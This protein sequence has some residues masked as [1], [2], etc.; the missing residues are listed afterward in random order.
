MGKG[1]LIASNPKNCP[2]IYALHNNC[3]NSNISV[4]F[5]KF[6]GNTYCSATN[7]LII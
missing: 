7:I 6:L 5:A 3:G 1:G 2:Y 4:D